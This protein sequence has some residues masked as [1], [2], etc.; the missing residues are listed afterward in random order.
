M[1]CVKITIILNFS[2]NFLDKKQTTEGKS[3]KILI[4]TSQVTYIP[5]NYQKLITELIEKNEQIYALAILNNLDGQVIKSAFGLIYLGATQVAKALFKNI[6][7][8]QFKNREK[9]AKRNAKKVFHFKSMNDPEAIQIVKE[10]EIDLIL[11]I[12][13]RCIYKKE[14]LNAPKLGCINVHHGLLPKYRGTLCDLYALY[15]KRPAGFSIHKMEKKIDA[16][17]IYK[18][19]EVDQ[20]KEINYLKYLDLTVEKEIV[21]L[22]ELIQYIAKNNE[23]PDGI[24]NK[25]DSIVF[26]K[27][28]TR[29]MIKKIKDKGLIV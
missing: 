29:E 4:V 2:T 13:T 3:L 27:N 19:V 8:C 21:H 11:N 23:L 12:R 24:E 14:I 26:T 20:G 15:E 5:D 17:K 25:T 9:V 1:H 10:H 28:P 6:L 22:T 16:G 18:I 7:S